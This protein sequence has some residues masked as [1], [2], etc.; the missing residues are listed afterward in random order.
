MYRS[1]LFG[2]HEYKEIRLVTSS[3][4]RSCEERELEE[5]EEHNQLPTLLKPAG[6]FGYRQDPNFGSVGKP[7]VNP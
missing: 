1:S 6:G 3:E 5:K 4:C 2:A 7:G